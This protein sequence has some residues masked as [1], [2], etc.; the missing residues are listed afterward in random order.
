M[1]GAI[2]N[3]SV[4]FD[5][6]DAPFLVPQ[7]SENHAVLEVDKHK[8]VFYN[9]LNFEHPD[10]YIF[11]S[12]PYKECKEKA[13]SVATGGFKEM[14]IMQ[15]VL[16]INEMRGENGKDLTQCMMSGSFQTT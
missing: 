1:F 15:K 5:E 8:P 10:Y 6:N 14:L 2:S 3:S 9:A 12:A 13:Y 16:K 4:K 7:E 11:S